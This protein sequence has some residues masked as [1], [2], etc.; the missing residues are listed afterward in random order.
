MESFQEHRYWRR[1][2]ASPVVLAIFFVIALFLIFKVGTL[3]FV[4]YKEQAA[5]NLLESDVAKLEERKE[6]VRVKIED[7]EFG[8]LLEKEARSSFNIKRPGEQTVIIIEGK[9]VEESETA[10]S[11]FFGKVKSWFSN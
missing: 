4:I 8:S 3:F 9:E 2:F 10:P 11:T 7:V 1:V 5:L 6:Q